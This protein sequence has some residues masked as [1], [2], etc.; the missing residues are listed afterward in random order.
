MTG[1]GFWLPAADKAVMRTPS[2]TCAGASATHG[3]RTP[4]VS[5]SGAQ[6]EVAPLPLAPLWLPGRW[7]QVAGRQPRPARP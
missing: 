6:S 5:A 1:C 4:C 7:A 3:V 2:L